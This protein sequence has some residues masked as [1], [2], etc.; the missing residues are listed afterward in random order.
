[1]KLSLTPIAGAMTAIGMA[2]AAYAAPAPAPEPATD[3]QIAQVDAIFARWAHQDTPGCAVA[4]SQGGQIV[5]Q[6]VYGMASLELGVP[7]TLD[8]IYEAGSDSKQFT[9]A[10][11]LMLARAGKLSLD[12]DIRK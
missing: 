8:S 11:T 9:A 4:V 6:R 7:A 2:G 10:A 12:D 3:A 5:A 1:M